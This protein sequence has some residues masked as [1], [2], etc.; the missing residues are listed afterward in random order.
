MFDVMQSSKAKKKKKR[1]NKDMSEEII[2]FWHTN[3]LASIPKWKLKSTIVVIVVVSF[4]FETSFATTN[5]SKMQVLP[6]YLHR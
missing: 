5:T 1:R 4:S 2:G 3:R 6:V